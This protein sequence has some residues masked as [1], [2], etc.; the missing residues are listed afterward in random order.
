MNDFSALQRLLYMTSMR[1]GVL[2]SNVAN[3]DTPHY[4]ARDIRFRE[5]LD[6]AILDL[7]AT[8]PGHIR[9]GFPAGTGG[10]VTDSDQ[11]WNDGN[12]VELEREV[13]KMT[14]NALLHQA[15]VTMLS[16]KIRMF[17]NA[18]RRT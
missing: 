6:G 8:H 11:P 17:K 13:A 5:V 15:G 12:D 9:V 16:T 3:A 4:K 2:S 1:Q 14:E 10:I 7:S 18:L